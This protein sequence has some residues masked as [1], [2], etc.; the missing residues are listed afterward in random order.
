MKGINLIN[1]GGSVVSRV[2]ETIINFWG[3]K[4]NLVS[5][6]YYIRKRHE[7]NPTL[8]IHPSSGWWTVKDAGPTMS[9]YDNRLNTQAGPTTVPAIARYS[10]S[11]LSLY[12]FSFSFSFHFQFLCLVMFS[13]CYLSF[14][15]M[16]AFFVT[17]NYPPL[18]HCMHQWMRFYETCSDTRTFI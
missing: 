15:K 6:S 1:W 13:H 2:T 12:K 10:L 5:F 3:K 7:K 16:H 8:A 11:L 18:F 9:M 17:I 4:R 14:F